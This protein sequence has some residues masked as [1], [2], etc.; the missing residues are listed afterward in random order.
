MAEPTAHSE[1]VEFST[2]MKFRRYFTMHPDPLFEAR[3]PGRLESA[4]FDDVV[5]SDAV[6]SL[7]NA[8]NEA[9]DRNWSQLQVPDGIKGLHLDYLDSAERNAFAFYV[10]D[11]A[12]IAITKAAVTK[13]LRIATSMSNSPLVGECLGVQEGF[14][15]AAVPGAVNLTGA[16][17]TTIMQ[18]LSSHEIGH[19]FH[20]HCFETARSL[21][22]MRTVLLKYRASVTMLSTA[23]D[24]RQWKSKPMDTQLT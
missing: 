1:Q 12:C 23:C 24:H 19:I 17:F 6:L 7:K 22:L 4:D 20:G 11:L 14:D 15:P 21:P 9:H 5:F 13:V 16:L 3:Y 18:V 10:D 8:I 2:E